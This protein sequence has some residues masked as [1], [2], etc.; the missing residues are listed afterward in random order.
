MKNVKII[1]YQSRSQVR[2]PSETKAFYQI[3]NGCSRITHQEL[4]AEANNYVMINALMTCLTLNRLQK[5]DG[6]T[7]NKHSNKYATLFC[8]AKNI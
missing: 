6:Q 2:F 8:I 4:G 7:R 5:S 1:K 3:L